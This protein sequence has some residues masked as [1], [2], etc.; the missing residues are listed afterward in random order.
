MTVVICADHEMAHPNVNSLTTQ[1]LLVENLCTEPSWLVT[2]DVDD[3]EA[4]ILHEGDFDLGFVQGAIRNAG[5]DPLGVPIATLGPTATDTNIAILTAGLVARH[6]EF[7]EASPEQTK[8]QW[9]KLMSRRRIFALGVPQY[10]GAPSIDASLCSAERGCRIC[11][12]NCPVSALK[13]TAGGIAHDIETCVACG[14]CV[15]SCP[16]GATVN[17]TATEAQ[18]IAQIRSLVAAADSPIG[19][20]YRCRE[21]VS[22]PLDDDWYPVEVPCVGMLTIG[23]LLAPL[24]LGAGAVSVPSCGDTGCSITNDARATVHL[25]E[26]T[27]ILT[28]LGVSPQ[29]LADHRQDT[30]GEALSDTDSTLLTDLN[31]TSVYLA[32]ATATAEADSV[33]AS[34]TGAVGVVSINELSCTACE[35]CVAVC[36][37]QA[38][39]SEQR[40]QTIEISFDST[41]CVGC[42]LCAKT[43]PE[44]EFDAIAIRHSFD[45]EELS[46]GRRVVYTG[47]T[48]ACE[49]CGN[50]IAPTAMLDRISAMLGSE[51]AGTTNL[52]TRRC[53]KC[54]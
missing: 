9:P 30:L 36:P 37:S 2:A 51:H 26:A 18:I 45:V 5:F 50:P 38:L 4:L 25:A 53:L 21:A 8:M 19:I 35:Q 34:P 41:R 15:T 22:A 32:L 33:V 28:D 40:D 10:I 42:D 13:P 7:H 54:R 17:P 49:V 24:L 52:I 27:A 6:R 3:I 39:T 47:A 46:L 12:D 48:S 14:I 11:V 29:R 43:C 31:D 20:E 23:W 44:R 1:V 16:T